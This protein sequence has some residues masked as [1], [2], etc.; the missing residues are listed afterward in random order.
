VSNETDFEERKKE[1]NAITSDKSR[2]L[3]HL[4]PK[5]KKRRSRQLVGWSAEQLSLVYTLDIGANIHMHSLDRKWLTLCRVISTLGIEEMMHPR[6]FF[7][8]FF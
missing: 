3:A 2:F 7:I 6:I 4:Q 8:Y 1:M 5:N